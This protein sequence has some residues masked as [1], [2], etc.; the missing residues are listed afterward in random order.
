VAKVLVT[1]G[2]G[3]K[4]TLLTQALLGAGHHVRR[5]DNFLY[6]FGPALPFAGHAECE[7][8]RKDIRN[9]TKQD[10]DGYA[11]VYHLAGISGYA[12]CEANPHSAQT[13]NVDSTRN[14]VSLLD[15]DQLFV[16][17]STTSLYGK[18]GERRNE[19]SIPKPVSVY[20]VTK[21]AAEKETR[22]HEK[23]VNFR[24]ATLFGASLKMRCDLMLNDFVFKA[25]TERSLVLF[26]EQS[27]RTFLHVRDAI[28][29]YMMVMERPA[30]FIGKTLNVGSDRMN[31]SKLEL[32]QRVCQYVDAEIIHSTLDDFDKRDFIIDFSRIHELGFKASVTIDEGIRELVRLYKWFSPYMHYQTI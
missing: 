23:T 28:T 14:L 5:L 16:N 24:F 8:V 6:G 13:I 1:G 22:K 21:Y 26:D 19:D 29:A 9:L 3:Y 32:A 7:I 4:G 25:V 27:V 2:A 11:V 20:G 15:A 12:A 17:A 10:V 30:L 18:S 31:F